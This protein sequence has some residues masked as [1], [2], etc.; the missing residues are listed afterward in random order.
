MNK[1]TIFII[2]A[3]LGVFFAFILTRF[4]FPGATW[5]TLAE[6][7]ILLVFLAYL[8]DFLRGQRK[9]VEK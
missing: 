3:L 7:G 6:I 2:R 4:F 5:T 8:F 1:R 9:D